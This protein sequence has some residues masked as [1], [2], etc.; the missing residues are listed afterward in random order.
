MMQTKPLN[1]LFFGLGSIGL[2]H[3]QLIQNHFNHHLFAY[4]TGK[5]EEKKQLSLSE[6][7][8]P[9]E[10]FSV[11]PDI[12][13]ITNPTYLHVDT[14]ISC[15]EHDVS[16]FFE[17]PLSHTLDNLN[18]LKTLVK[19]KKLFTYV[20]YNLRFH[21][22]LMK[23]RD[24]LQEKEVEYFRVS[25][26]SY[27][28]HWR[29]N[30]DYTKSYSA[31]SLL[32]GGAILEL[33]HEFDYISW[34]FGK[35]TS[36]SGFCGKQSTLSIDCEDVVDAHITCE[37][38]REGSLYLNLFSFTNERMI[39]VFCSDV[40]Y[41]A[42]LIKNTLTTVSNKGKK[43][44]TTFKITRNELYLRQLHYVFNQFLQKR[45]D[46]MNDIDEASALLKTIIKF[47]TEQCIK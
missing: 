10:A 45:N 12:A 42:D 43:R 35:I 37:K 2:R 29:P 11:H 26:C 28:P 41:E 22:I 38:N 36:L 8:D 6:F 3:A 17:K 24:L 13:F 16:L 47:K 31:Q 1:L 5:G 7:T 32:G 15:A 20:A 27:L 39:Q 9:Q 19:N 14:A 4:R 23:L 40:Q 44:T 21:P 25:C 46:T 34:I 18:L 33:S 30:Q